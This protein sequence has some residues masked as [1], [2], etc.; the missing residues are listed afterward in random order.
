MTFVISCECGYVIRGA[1]EEELVRAA[2][3]HISA[4]H[5]AIAA[6]ASDADYLAMAERLDDDEP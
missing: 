4:N 6:E 3:E 2:R 5:P 1:N